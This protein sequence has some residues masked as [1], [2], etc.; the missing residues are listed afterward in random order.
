MA[1]VYLGGK[2]ASCGSSEGLEIDHKIPRSRGGGGEISNL[3]LL[4][5]I[6]HRIKSREE[7][8]LRDNKGGGRKLNTITTEGSLEGLCV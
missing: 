7:Q 2:C 6:C 5:K 1:R 3:Q 4:C 8:R